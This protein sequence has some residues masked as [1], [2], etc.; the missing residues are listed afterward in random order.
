MI[1]PLNIRESL[2]NCYLIGHVALA[3]G[4]HDAFPRRP[5]ARASLW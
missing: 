1:D 2:L 4:L 3:I 5:E